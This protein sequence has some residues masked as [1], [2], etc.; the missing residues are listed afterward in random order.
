MSAPNTPT[1]FNVQSGNGNVFVSWDQMLSPLA[2]SYTVQ[3]SLDGITYS[4]VATPS[5]SPLANYFLDNTTTSDTSYWYQVLASNI[6][7]SSAYTTPQQVIPCPIGIMP[8]GYLRLMSQQRADLVNSQFLSLTEWNFNIS[9]SYKELWDLLAQKYG[10]D[11][12]VATPYTFTTGNGLQFYPLPADFYKLLGV[13]VALNPGDSNSWVSLRKFEFVQR[14]LW[15][16]PNVYTFYGITNL[17]Y[18]LNGNNLYIVPLPTGGQTLRIWYVPR[19]VILMA[20]TDIM[21]GVSGWEEYVIVDAARKARLKQESPTDELM[22]EKLG[23]IQRI[24]SAAEN[25]DVGEP[26]TV[27]DSRVRNFA[28]GSDDGYGSPGQNGGGY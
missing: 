23:L 28:W 10:D 3:R 2:T 7:G 6:S 22:N 8:L 12:F 19:P 18:R 13:E 17:R 5:G 21:D 20:D 27:S 1:N 26:E 9:Q 4:T 15:N 14:N 24:E 25:R 11:Y 16:Y